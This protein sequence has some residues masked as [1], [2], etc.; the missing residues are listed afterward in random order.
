MTP[1]PCPKGRTYASDCL[2]LGRTPPL[3]GKG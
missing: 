2:S 1:L 3:Q